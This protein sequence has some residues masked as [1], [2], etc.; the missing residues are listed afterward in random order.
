MLIPAT[1]CNLQG[2]VSWNPCK[3]KLLFVCKNEIIFLKHFHKDIG[4]VVLIHTMKAY[5]VNG[6][7]APHILNPSIT[8]R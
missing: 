8:D 7:I 3:R 1:L 4:H 2:S 5:T 6:G